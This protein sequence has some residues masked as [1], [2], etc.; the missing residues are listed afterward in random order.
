MNFGPHREP[1]DPQ[2]T[3][4][5]WN[6]RRATAG[7]PLWDYLLELDPDVALLQEVGG[8]SPAVRE[9][10][11][12]DLV[13]AAWKHGEP[14]KFCTGMLVRGD[15]VGDVELSA[16]FDW[17]DDVLARFGGNLV[18]REVRLAGGRDVRVISVYSPAWTVDYGLPEGLDT[19]EVRLPTNAGLWLSDVLWS[20]LRQRPPAPEA[21]WIVGGDLNSSPTF[22]VRRPLAGNQETLDRMARLGLVECLRSSQGRLQPSRGPRKR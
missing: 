17:V 20:C 13:P 15:I 14:L 12:C 1:E 8:V 4:V 5:S 16:P 3:V 21:V 2:F 22:D 19:S 10:Y 7:S 18:G 11:A 9:R 6:C